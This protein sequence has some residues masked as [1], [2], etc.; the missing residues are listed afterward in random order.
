MDP[1]SED[2]EGFIDKTQERVCGEVKVKLYKGGLQ[3]IG[4]SSP[5]SLYDFNL[6][7][8]DIQTTFNQSWSEG[9]IE[10]WGLPT[11]I[12]HILKKKMEDRKKG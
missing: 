2:L 11:R 1:L 7:T 3:V 10:I 8:Y 6:A 12:S 4:R 5:M 9:F